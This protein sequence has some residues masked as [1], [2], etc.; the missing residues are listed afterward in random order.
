MRYSCPA[1]QYKLTVF[2]LKIMV[3][4]LQAKL[5]MNEEVLF[6]IFSFNRILIFLSLAVLSFFTF[7]L[8][9]LLWATAASTREE[10]KK[11]Q[12]KQ[13]K[14]TE[15]K[16]ALVCLPHTLTALCVDLSGNRVGRRAK[17]QNCYNSR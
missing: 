2:A 8:I 16:D 9:F 6:C 5:F 4:K 7:S 11:K 12:K 17:E 14:T 1:N 3:L 10:K 15:K 13:K